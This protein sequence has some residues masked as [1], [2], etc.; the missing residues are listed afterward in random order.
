MR[1]WSVVHG[2]PGLDRSG[3]WPIPSVVGMLLHTPAPSDGA[4]SVR[5][6]QLALAALHE[7]LGDAR[8][9]LMA[10]REVEWVSTAADFYR[11]LL[12]ETLQDLA[13]LSAALSEA[14][15]AVLHHASAADA[16]RRAS[17]VESAMTEHLPVWTR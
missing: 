12:G 7:T 5:R 9:E 4:Q 2:R 11:Q 1:R 3:R 17:G 14:A 15:G 13:R 6:A 8:R 16:A 10:A